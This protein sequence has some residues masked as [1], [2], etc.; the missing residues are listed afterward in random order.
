MQK[1]LHCFHITIVTSEKGVKRVPIKRGFKEE[2]LGKIY[3]FNTPIIDN[4]A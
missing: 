3:V 4:I 2:E 1:T